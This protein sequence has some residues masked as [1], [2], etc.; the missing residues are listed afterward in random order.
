[1]TDLAIVLNWQAFFSWNPDRVDA[2]LH[3]RTRVFGVAGVLGLPR[4]RLSAPDKPATMSFVKRRWLA[5]FLGILLLA[6]SAVAES[7][8]IVT[9]RMMFLPLRSGTDLINASNLAVHDEFFRQH[10]NYRVESAT[11]L[12]LPEGLSEAQQMMAFAGEQGP[13]VFEISM[14]MVQNY[15]RQGLVAPLDDLVEEHKRAHPGWEVPTLGL[16]ED[17]WGAAQGD[18]G[19]L[20]ALMSDYWIHALWYRRDLFEEAGIVPPRP[21][22]D[23][24]EYYE[25]A[26]RLTFPDKFVE[27]AQFQS[28]QYGTLISTSY[29]AGFA[30]TNF[31]FQAGGNMTMQERVCPDDGTANEFPKEDRVCACTQCGRSLIDEPR[32]WKA[33]YGREPGQR[34]LR[35]YKRLRWSEW[36]RCPDCQT[37]NDLPVAVCPSCDEPNPVREDG[38]TELECRVCAMALSL[39]E[40]ETLLRCKE[41]GRNLRDAPVYT[42][43]V[44][45]AAGSSAMA[46]AFQR[47]EIAMLQ[48]QVN[49]QAIDIVLSQGGLRPDQLGLGPPPTAPGGARHAITGGRAWCLNAHAARDPKILKAAWQFMVFRCSE[50]AQRITTDVYVKSGYAHLVRPQLLKKFGYDEEYEDYEPGFRDAMENAP[51]YGRVQP[52]D[53]HYQHVEGTEL[54]VPVDHIVYQGGQYLDPKQVIEA[55]MAQTNQKLYRLIP[56]SKAR[57]RRIWAGFIFCLV[58]PLV[59]AGFIYTLRARSDSGTL[60]SRASQVVGSGGLRRRNTIIAWS[61]MAPAL[62]TVLLWQYL[63]LLRGTVMAFFDYRIYG[64]GEFIWLDNFVEVLLSPDFWNSVRA[65]ILYVGI[66]LGI[67]FVAPILLALLV[68]EVPRGKMLYRTLFYLPAVTTGIVIMFLW[69]MFYAPHPQGFLNRLAMPVLHLF[70]VV[71]PDVQYIDWLHTPGIAMLCVIIPGVWAGAGPGSL[72]YLAALKTVPEDLYESIAI[73]GGTFVHKIRHVMYPALKPLIMI[74]FIGAFI[75]SFHA[76]QNVFVMTGGGPA[77]STMVLGIHIWS[78]AFLYLRF[79]YATAMAWVLGSILIG[80]TVMQL[81]IL[82]KVEFRAAH[83]VE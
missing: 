30:F 11:G 22:K 56:E 40:E 49:P 68:S 36:T 1:M 15:I 32:T 21:P 7:D 27:G 41:C 46:E 43:V 66:S 48:Q 37:P 50:E 26:Q 70:H 80:F 2:G 24:D 34:A 83:Q 13:D 3:T 51:S 64:G 18:D 65:T 5:S 74:N 31:V 79:G 29:W 9:F 45:T 47:G 54:A 55:S 4:L 60:Q 25:F 73:D 42:G 33:T 53:P 44:R 71:G 38:Q 57:R 77:N 62:V 67:G 58:A 10:P 23:W 28:G 35:F 63:P 12:E 59:V 14:R 17:H 20:Y 75:G 82:K 61:V 81:R 52:H 19:R 72:I 69:K 16:S 78:N 8:D 39:P 76:M 6:G